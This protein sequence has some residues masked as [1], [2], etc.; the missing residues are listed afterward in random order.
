MDEISTSAPTAVAWVTPG[1]I[2]MSAI[3]PN[4]YGLKKASQKDLTVHSVK[5]SVARAGHILSGKEKGAARDLIVLNA[6][7]GL[8]LCGKAKTVRQGIVLA[9]A[10]LDSGKALE[11]LRRLRRSTTISHP[12]CVK[13]STHPGCEMGAR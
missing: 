4:A 5:E 2:R 7:Y 13:R 12:G 6:A 10:S 9:K 1:K 11:A 3:L 8:V